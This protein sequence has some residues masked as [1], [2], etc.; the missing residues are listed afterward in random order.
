MS[1]QLLKSITERV[2]VESHRG[3]E[4]LAPENSWRGLELAHH[5][6]ADWIEVDTQLSA[7]GVAFLRHN[8]SLP[9]Q[10]ACRD[11]EWA[12]IASL[13][14]QGEP[15]PRLESVLEWARD[16]NAHLS[17][18]L[19]TAFTPQTKLTREV[20]RLVQKTHTQDR[21][22]LIAWDH[23]ELVH[24]K[25]LFPEIKTRALI[26]GRLVDLPAALQSVGADC[27]SLS[28]DLIR[29]GDVEE[30]HSLGVAVVLA[31]LWQPDFD[32]VIESGADM[33]SW[34]DPAEAKRKLQK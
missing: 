10:R 15:L 8:Y 22:L 26:R 23:N 18:D 12:E 13:T 6:G 3:A 29:P 19:K 24:A 25:H 33:V 17:L 30:M 2:L 11:V 16:T 1:L 31:D 7:D 9:D 20:V 14:I 27:V 21:V 32:F 5:L 4:K 28:Y 34:G